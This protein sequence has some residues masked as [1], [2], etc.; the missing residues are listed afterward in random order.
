[1]G[2]QKYRVVLPNQ[3][4]PPRQNAPTPSA[5]PPSQFKVEVG[6]PSTST[7]ENAGA[8]SQSA[9]SNPRTIVAKIVPRSSVSAGSGN[10]DGPPRS[11]SNQPLVA[12]SSPPPPH[13]GAEF[14]IWTNTDGRQVEA[15][16]SEYFD[17]GRITLQTRDGRSPTIPLAMFSRPDQDY[18]TRLQPVARRVQPPRIEH[19]AGAQRNELRAWTSRKGQRAEAVLVAVDHARMTLKTR[20]GQNITV[21]VAEFSDEDQAYVTNWMKSPVPSSPDAGP[22]HDVPHESHI[23]SRNDT[24]ALIQNTQ[25]A[26]VLGGELMDWWSSHANELELVNLSAKGD[27]LV[28]MQAF[29]TTM[30]SSSGTT[31]VMGCLQTARFQLDPSAPG[32][33]IALQSLKS[34]YAPRAGW[35]HPDGRPAGFGYDAILY[36][37]NAS[38]AIEAFPNGKSSTALDF[39]TV[40]AAHEWLL[41]QVDIHDFLLATPMKPIAKWVG[42]FVKESAYVV[43]HEMY[44][45]PVGNP[46]PGTVAECLFGYSFLPCGAVSGPFGFG[47][48]HFK[49]AIKQFRFSLLESGELEVT[50]SFI[51][52]PRSQKV[53]N[54]FGFDPV[55]TMVHFMNAITFGLL[56]IKKFAHNALDKNFMTVHGQVHH[57]FLNGMEDFWTKQRW[58][59]GWQ[60]GAY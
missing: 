53:L 1:M 33:A 16:L 6:P 2:K 45:K 40:G 27:H 52:S 38:G 46:R 12:S 13:A 30:P 18:V 47:P 20:N 28:D 48:G 36:K 39:S 54:L 17:D 5:N 7:T 57:N 19:S 55:Y 56:G 31:S 32:K 42:K 44:A 51:V 59:P 11:P 58:V 21:P 4:P 9:N 22:A 49:S 26:L 24:P 3:S 35:F 43:S 34:E 29:F 10:Q 37:D 14:R 41:L 15:A 23:V 25:E 8:G 60:P 50:L